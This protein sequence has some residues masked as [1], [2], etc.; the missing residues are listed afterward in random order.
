MYEFPPDGHGSTSLRTTRRIIR[1]EIPFMEL[2]GVDSNTKADTDRIDQD[3]FPAENRSCGGPGS[4]A[5]Q[6]RYYKRRPRTHQHD[7]EQCCSYLASGAGPV[8]CMARFTRC[9]LLLT[10]NQRSMME[11]SAAGEDCSA[12]TT[13]QI[14][15]SCLQWNR[16]NSAIPRPCTAAIGGM[17]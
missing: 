15:D 10:P 4:D 2:N 16:S 9:S 6:N 17:P 1:D 5:T 14:G 7:S 8:A 12:P 3:A 11:T 13:A